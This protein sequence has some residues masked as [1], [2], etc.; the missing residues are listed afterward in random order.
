MEFLN[1]LGKPIDRRHCSTNFR[2]CISIN[3]CKD[4]PTLRAY[5]LRVCAMTF[6]NRYV[7]LGLSAGYV[8]LKNTTQ[9]HFQH[10]GSQLVRSS[11]RI[12]GSLTQRI[13]QYKHG[14]Q[15]ILHLIRLSQE[16]LHLEQDAAFMTRV[17]GQTTSLSNIS[18]VH[19]RKKRST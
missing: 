19:A 8:L 2:H 10:T 15:G 16:L 5:G 4:H 14:S 11:I 3:P 1:E 13:R 18:G 17:L 12:S 6:G 9:S 7:K